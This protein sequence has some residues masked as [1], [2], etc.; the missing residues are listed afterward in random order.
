MVWWSSVAGWA[1]AGVGNG[2]SVPR[3][4]C[5]PH[6]CCPWLSSILRK[7]SELFLALACGDLFRLCVF[8]NIKQFVGAKNL[9]LDFALKKKSIDILKGI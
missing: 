4:G 3:T 1:D 9:N 6:I 7:S 8:R 2:P 5:F